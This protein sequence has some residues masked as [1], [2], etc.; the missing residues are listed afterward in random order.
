MEGV[1]TLWKYGVCFYYMESESNMIYLSLVHC[2]SSTCIS[3]SIYSIC[4]YDSLFIYLI[5]LSMYISVSLSH[6]SIYLSSGNFVRDVHPYQ[7]PGGRDRYM[8]THMHIHTT[9]KKKEVYVLP[10]HNK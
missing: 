8:Y 7:T 2:L 1:Y 10:G 9:R 4:A 5:Y 3:C 6:L